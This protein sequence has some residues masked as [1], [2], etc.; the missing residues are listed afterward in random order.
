MPTRWTQVH[1]VAHWRDGGRTDRANLLLLCSHHHHAAHDGRWT[2]I[3]EAPGKMTAKR[4]LRSDDP[5][6]EIRNLQPPHRRSVDS[7]SAPQ[8]G[9]YREADEGNG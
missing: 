8:A 1:H 6:Y 5:Y 9:V 2:V 7:N 4:R 3:Q